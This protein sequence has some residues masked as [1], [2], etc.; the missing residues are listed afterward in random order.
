MILMRTEHVEKPPMPYQVLALAVIRQAADDYRFLAR[1]IKSTGSE[2]ERKRLVR[3]M[4][5]IS[6]FFLSDWFC[7]LSGSDEGAE[8]LERL[9]Q[10]V[11]GN[12]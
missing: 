4:M 7:M 9:D 10:E 2:L 12:D 3:E 1:H 8:I 6:R 5:S 11:L